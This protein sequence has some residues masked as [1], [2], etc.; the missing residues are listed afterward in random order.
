MDSMLRKEQIKD[1]MIQS[2]AKLWDIPENQIEKNFDPLVML[3]FEAVASELEK[4]GLRINTIRNRLISRM[5]EQIVPQAILKSRPASCVIQSLP[6]ENIAEINKNVSFKS[7]VKIHSIGEPVKEEVVKFTP[8]GKFR[9]LKAKLP[10]V[11]IG[12]KVISSNKEGVFTVLSDGGNSKL[13]NKIHFAIK[14]DESLKNLKG[15]SLFFDLSGHSE[16]ENFFFALS[17]AIVT[18]NNDE[19]KFCQGYQYNEQF[20][21]NLSEVL[22]KFENKY[23]KKIEK[24]VA[25]IYKRNFYFIDSD[26][27]IQKQAIPQDWEQNVNSK[28]LEQLNTDNYIF[29]TFHLN[30]YFSPDVLSRIQFGINAFPVINR[31]LIHLDYPTDPWVNVIPLPTEYTFL[32]VHEISGINDKYEEV[33]EVNDNKIEEG[34]AI[35]RTGEMGSL[36]SKNIQELV[37]LLK[38]SIHDQSAYF[39]RIG[40]DDITINLKEIQRI[41]NRLEDRVHIS[42][43][44]RSNYHY[45]LLNA[46]KKESVVHVSYWVTDPNAAQFLK[47]NVR[48]EADRHSE[49]VSS[50]TFS[51]TAALGGLESPNEISKNN[52]LA[53]YLSSGGKI[54]SEDDLKRICIII[55]SEKLKSVSVKKVV[56]PM[57]GAKIGVNRFIEI[58]L[59]LHSDKT[60]TELTNYLKLRLEHTLKENAS[61]ALPFQINIEEH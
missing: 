11:L 49:S 43:K 39:S 53:L 28:L 3:L 22:N 46:L 44:L 32:D 51:L 7:T 5:V 33:L 42:K 8:I 27:P 34:K 57:H 54:V 47:S 29:L 41:I 36:G 6:S 20:E 37:A 1:R 30:H 40:N 26:L 59:K 13:V 15:L 45:L 16:T 14:A 18:A 10:Y 4:T 2:A 12:N 25:G 9:L 60:N 61:I 48:F 24:E 35:L 50:E 38:E 58:N 31:T 52:A 21:L 56:K 17:S 55:F 23:V 19:I